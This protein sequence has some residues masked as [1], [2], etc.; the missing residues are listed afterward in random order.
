MTDFASEF[1][2]YIKLSWKTR[3]DSVMQAQGQLMNWLFAVHGAGIAGSL[4]YATAKGLHC[5][6]A[7]GLAAFVA[8]LVAL[9]I[10]GTLMYYFEERRFAKFKDQV[11]AVE[12]GAV[13]VATFIAEQKKNSSKYR[14]CEVIAWLSGV[15]GLVGLIC[16]IVTVLRG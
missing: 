4:G 11:D 10:Y 7:V 5:T 6:L 3:S 14:S 12:L 16:F 2:E 15:A 1:K 13:T 9:L 8:G